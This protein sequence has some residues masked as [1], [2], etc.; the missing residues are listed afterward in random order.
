MKPVEGR[1]YTYAEKRSIME[2]ILAVWSAY[3]DMRLGQ[4]LVNSHVSASPNHNSDIFYVEDDKLA[5]EVET[6]FAKLPPKT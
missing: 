3:P 4:L 2:K 1:A 5:E 6:F